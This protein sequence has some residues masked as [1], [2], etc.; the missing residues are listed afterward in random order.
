MSLPASSTFSA[1]D[2]RAHFHI[3]QA[4]DGREL[5][6]LCGHSLGA[7]PRD[8]KTV[9]N[10]GMKQWAALAVDGHFEGA[11]PWFY[12]GEDLRDAMGHI[13]GAAAQDVVLQGTLTNNLHLLLRSFYRPQ[14]KRTRI[15]MEHS[16]FPSDRFCIR[17]HVASRG[18]DPD[19][20]VLTVRGKGPYGVPTTQ[21]ILEV[22]D[23]HGDEIATVLLPGVSYINGAV[24]DI[25]AITERA[26]SVGALAGWDLAHA[27]GNIELSLEEHNV[28]FAAWCTYKYLNSGPGAIGGLFVHPRHTAPDAPPLARYEGWWGNDAETRFTP[29]TDF[30]PA[31][32]AA[33]WQ[34]SNVPVFS[35]LPLYASL[36]TFQHIGMARLAALGHEAHRNV[37]AALRDALPNLVFLTPEDAHGTQLSIQMDGRAGALQKALQEVHG[38]VCDTR[39]DDMLRVAPVPLYNNA[40]DIAH[41]VDAFASTLSSF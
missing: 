11:K 31:P 36:P 9:I 23:A 12:L 18:Y 13:V 30:D 14:N 16:A 8:A 5:T 3:P 7:M 19:E 20:H 21:E 35:L 40:Q 2:L 41:F 1:G 27:A 15:L 37:R 32:G 38:I 28:D 34:L 24:Y 29:N 22:L 17:S 6:Y 25:A 10:E 26:Q 4:A 33:A 39:G